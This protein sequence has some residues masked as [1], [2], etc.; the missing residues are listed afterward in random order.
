MGYDKNYV[1]AATNLLDE[2]YYI[3]KT[4]D[5]NERWTNHKSSARKGSSCYFH[6]ALNKY[7]AENF[8][9]KILAETETEQEALDLERLW[10][11]LTG[12]YKEEIGYNLT[13]GGDGVRPNEA[14][15]KKE[16]AANKGRRKTEEE[17]EHLRRINT[18]RRHSLESIAKMRIVQSG[19]VTSEETKAK[20]S[21]VRKGRF[22]GE[23]HPM[24]GKKHSEESRKKMSE[25]LSGRDSWNNGLPWGEETR[26]KMSEGQKKRFE[27]HPEDR[28]YLSN[29]SKQLWRNPEYRAKMKASQDARYAREREE[30]LKAAA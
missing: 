6:R 9:L 21:A 28:E 5:L 29:K 24:Y 26:Q 10:I 20:Q 27:D 16:S 11:I 8:D 4:F 18:G 17:K 23:N 2:K 14:T 7:G 15:R 3:G 22:G 25:S 30:K 19:R 1:Y 12:S 13:F